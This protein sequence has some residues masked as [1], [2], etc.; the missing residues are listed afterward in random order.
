MNI[1]LFFKNGVCVCVCVWCAWC[2]LYLV[3]LFVCLLRQGC[4]VYPWLSWNSYCKPGW[5][6]TQRSIFV[7]LPRAL[8][9]G[10]HHHAQLN[11]CV[12]VCVCIYVG[13]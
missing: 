7:Y 2:V 6:L 5:P 1:S 3:C 9:K 12:G 8:I 11:M 10:M 4:S 13:G